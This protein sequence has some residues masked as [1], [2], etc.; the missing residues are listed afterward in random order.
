ML[1]TALAL[2]RY[3]LRHGSYP[4]LLEALTPELLPSR[5]LDFMDGAPLRYQHMQDGRFVL[6]SA[7]LDCIDDGGIG[8][9]PGLLSANSGHDHTDLV[10]PCPASRAEIALGKLPTATKCPRPIRPDALFAP[11]R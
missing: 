2:E 5:P 6:Y 4:E 11:D 10:W 9:K 3:R 8:R 1:V 7:G